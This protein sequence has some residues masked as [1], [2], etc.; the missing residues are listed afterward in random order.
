MPPDQQQRCCYRFCAKK[1]REDKHDIHISLAHDGAGRTAVA[2]AAT[3]FIPV[4]LA[5]DVE[6]IV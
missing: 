4:Q 2:I 1:K 6:S 5:K 3:D